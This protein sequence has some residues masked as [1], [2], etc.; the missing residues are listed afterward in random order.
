MTTDVKGANTSNAP[1]DLSPD[2]EKHERFSGEDS[3]PRRKALCGWEWKDE[4]YLSS[5]CCIINHLVRHIPK[6]QM[7]RQREAVKGWIMEWIMW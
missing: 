5:A 3:I 6:L 1:P 4:S 2:K 7:R